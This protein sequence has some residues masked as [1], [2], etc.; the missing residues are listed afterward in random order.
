MSWWTCRGAA[1]GQSRKDPCHPLCATCL[2][3]GSPPSKVSDTGYGAAKRTETGVW[4]ECVAWLA[5]VCL[6]EKARAM[7]RAKKLSAHRRSVILSCT[8]AWYYSK[9]H[10]ILTVDG[11]KF[12]PPKQT[13]DMNT[14]IQ[15]AIPNLPPLQLI[16]FT[17]NSA[18]PLA[19]S[20][21]A[22]THG[23]AF[24]CLWNHLP[25]SCH[26]PHCTT[27]D[28]ECAY[29]IY[30]HSQ[31][32]LAVA[33]LRVAPPR[34]WLPGRLQLAA[35][36]ELLLPVGDA[37]HSREHV[38]HRMEVAGDAVGNLNQK[39]VFVC[40]ACEP[41]T[42]KYYTHKNTRTRIHT[43]EYTHKN[44]YTRIHTQEFICPLSSLSSL[45]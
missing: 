14:N 29:W 18:S 45:F 3:S 15:N 41:S 8:N 5:R 27:S 38:N 34:A 12:A 21:P 9:K 6:Q 22:Q 35:L 32:W 25:Q 28:S 4:P 7:R 39:C 1:A 19:V 26:R 23:F 42:T 16:R 43:Q 44:T 31:S 2:L 36:R 24:N 33:R 11:Q 13:G 20:G 40:R 10:I 30:S 17:L 37:A